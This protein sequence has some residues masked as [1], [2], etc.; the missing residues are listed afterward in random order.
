M[1]LGERPL[2][3]GGKIIN[4]LEEGIIRSEPISQ[5]GEVLTFATRPC[6][7]TAQAGALT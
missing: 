3:L 2:I 5:P 4:L 7:S 1:D 6:P